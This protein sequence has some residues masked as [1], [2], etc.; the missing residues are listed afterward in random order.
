MPVSVPVEVVSCQLPAA[1]YRLLVEE[2]EIRP[3]LQSPDTGWT[4]PALPTGVPTYC[5][6]ILPPDTDN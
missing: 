2:T 4:Y 3:F 6:L 5:T 1:S